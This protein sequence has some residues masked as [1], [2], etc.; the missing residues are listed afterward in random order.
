MPL[1]LEI[2][3]EKSKSITRNLTYRQPN[4]DAKKFEKHLILWTNEILK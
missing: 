1:N 3:N 4:G 2:A